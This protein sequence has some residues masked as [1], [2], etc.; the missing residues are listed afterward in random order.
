MQPE[1]LAG[2]AGAVGRG[3]LAAVSSPPPRSL[4]AISQQG[5]GCPG[6]MT[7]EKLEQSRTRHLSV[8]CGHS[9][10]GGGGFC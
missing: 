2:V 5:W 10:T 1:L 6:G 7:L 8:P 9:D 3:R 4:S